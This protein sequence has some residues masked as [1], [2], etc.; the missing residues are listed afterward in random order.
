MSPGSSHR[1]ASTSILC[2]LAAPCPY[3]LNDGYN[4][5]IIF[6]PACTFWPFHGEGRSTHS[7]LARRAVSLKACASCFHSSQVSLLFVLHPSG[8]MKYFPYFLFSFIDI[9]HIRSFRG[10]STRLC[11]TV[12]GLDSARPPQPPEL[13][14]SHRRTWS[15]PVHL[16]YYSLLRVTDRT[17]HTV[18]PPL[19]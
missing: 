8:F 10:D 1:G 19:C 14:R 13:R 4:Q 2:L 7:R 16:P 9:F 17:T 11:H 5:F 18:N 6:Y 12:V 3:F 15:T